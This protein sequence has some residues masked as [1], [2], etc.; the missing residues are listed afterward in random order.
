[1]HEWTEKLNALDSSH[2]DGNGGKDDVDR[3][4]L[5]EWRWWGM[6]KSEGDMVL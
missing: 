2:M 4:E 1:M 5:G 3:W 6:R